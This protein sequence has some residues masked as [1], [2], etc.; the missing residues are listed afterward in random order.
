MTRQL[1]AI[2]KY[3]R[4]RP[5]GIGY[6]VLHLLAKNNIDVAGEEATHAC[7]KYQLCGGLVEG[8]EEYWIFIT[9]DTCN[10]FN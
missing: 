4:V 10:D 8:I 6:V 2:N 1:T 5:V 9:I 3:P 7:G